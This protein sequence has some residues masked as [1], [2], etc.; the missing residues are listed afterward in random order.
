[1]NKKIVLLITLILI[2]AL[3]LGACANPKLSEENS[4]GDDGSNSTN[5]PPVK[6]KTAKE[7]IEEYLLSIEDNFSA[8]GEIKNNL[9]EL[10]TGGQKYSISVDGSKIFTNNNGEK[11]YVEKTADDREY[12]YLQQDGTW[13]KRLITEEDNYPSDMSILTDLLDNVEWKRYDATTNYA[14][15]QFE[16]D[17]NDLWIECTMRTNEAT[18]LIYNIRHSWLFGD[19][20]LLIGNIKIYDVGS[21]VVTLPTN[22]VDETNDII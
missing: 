19:S 21:T 18:V 6:P 15:G 11:Y 2:I 22:A 5:N 14:E 8:S 16:Y 13:R 7:A 3:A 1:M 9:G 17:G 12:V 20:L 4:T 10:L